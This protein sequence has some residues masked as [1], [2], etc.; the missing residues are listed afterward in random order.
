MLC[1][2]FP[3]CTCP[4]QH[5]NHRALTGRP[6]EGHVLLWA[7]YLAPTTPGRVWSWPWWQRRRLSLHPG[8]GSWLVLLIRH[9]RGSL[10]AL[11]SP[12]PRRT[13][14]APEMANLC[15]P[16]PVIVPP[17]PATTPSQLLAGPLPGGRT[18]RPPSQWGV[19]KGRVGTE[20]RKEVGKRGD[21]VVFRSQEGRG[22]QRSP[23]LSL[24]R[25]THFSG[26]EATFLHLGQ[27]QT[28][29][30]NWDSRQRHGPGILSSFSLSP[31]PTPL[32][33]PFYRGVSAESSVS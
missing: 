6:A 4:T 7:P 23:S 15:A 5:P 33:P 1:L 14:F 11:S 25:Q 16:F 3:D 20:E 18:S 9:K 10:L 8:S 22:S 30:S 12:N 31:F 32:P 21:P 28:T 17:A 29:V 2:N 24:Y 13:Y 27:A 26:V 19:G